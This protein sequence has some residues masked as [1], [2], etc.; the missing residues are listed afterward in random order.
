V[1][2]IRVLIVDDSAVVRRVVT[3]VIQEDRALEVAG[4]ATNGRSGLVQVQECAPDV[5]VLDVDMPEMNGLEMLAE[6]RKTRPTL[7]VVMFSSHTEKGAATTLDALSL[8]ASDYVTKPSGMT[9]DEALHHLRR[10]LIPRLKALCRDV[11]DMGAPVE[12][13][14]AWGPFRPRPQGRIPARRHVEILAIGASTGGPDALATLLAGLPRELPVPIVVV[15]HMPPHFTRLLA[16][17][18]GSKVTFPVAEGVSGTVLRPGEVWIAPGGQH[19][20]V[21]RDGTSVR[22][23]LT[24]DPPENSCRPSVDVLFRSV[25][26]V[27]G[28]SAL[29]IVMTGM[30]RDG[31]AGCERIWE[32]Q[33]R[34]LVQNEATSVV[35]GMPGLVAQAGLAEDVL[36]LDQLTARI[37]HELSDGHASRAASRIIRHA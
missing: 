23:R 3:S 6:L 27:Y 36:P 29:A 18:L 12:P 7:P 14:R 19:M 35:W 21:V 22:L 24:T 11:V 31:L 33:G 9:G 25:A 2:R 32:A 1:R 5:V 17:R 8:G 13:L 4:T 28:A 16:G 30:G 26:E 20:T 34:I 15:Q 37:G 10:E